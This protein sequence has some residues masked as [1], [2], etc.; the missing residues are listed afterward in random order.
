ME[1]LIF[2]DAPHPTK[3]TRLN[4]LNPLQKLVYL[5]LKILVMPVMAASG[6]LYM[7]YRYP[8]RYGTGTLSASGLESVAV[9]HTAGA[10]LLVAFVVGHVY[11]T[12][13]G[14]SLFSN[15]KAMITGYEELETA[16]ASGEI[17]DDSL[18]LGS[19]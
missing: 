19:R 12:T 11:L 17:A 15:L 7:F 16:R 3:K 14:P 6:L 2:R 1:N 9:V 18:S 8:H 10:F 4:K 13:T 5:A